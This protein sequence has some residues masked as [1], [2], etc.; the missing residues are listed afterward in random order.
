MALRRYADNPGREVECPSAR[1]YRV[2][3]GSFDPKLFELDEAIKRLA[4]YAEVAGD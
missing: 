3:G 1:A 2:V 4:E